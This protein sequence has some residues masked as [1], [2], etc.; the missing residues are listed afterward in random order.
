M[1]SLRKNRKGDITGIALGIIVGLIFLAVMLPIGLSV[2]QS[3]GGAISQAGW[4]AAANT[5]M[6]TTTTN[7]GSGFS[8]LAI[9]PLVLAA[10]GI[11]ALLVVAFMRMKG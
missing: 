7:I 10:G 4:T 3:I 5:T 6:T 11:I 2:W 9:A 1:R 8:L